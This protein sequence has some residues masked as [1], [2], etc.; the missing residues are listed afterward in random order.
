MIDDRRR[1]LSELSS[2]SFVVFAYPFSNIDNAAVV[3]EAIGRE[4]ESRSP[5]GMGIK[6]SEKPAR[7][8]KVLSE[9][10][11]PHRGLFITSKSPLSDPGRHST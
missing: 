10:A 3:P 11:R 5:Q 1:T 4:G 2:Q 7:V 8:N 9:L 6:R